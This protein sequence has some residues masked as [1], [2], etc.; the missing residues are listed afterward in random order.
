MTAV[1]VEQE[2]DCKTMAAVVE[3][4][5]VVRKEPDCKIVTVVAFVVAVRKGLA[6][7][8]VAVAVVAL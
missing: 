6:A 3:V 2:P 4:V 5:V 8:V 7:A 1:A